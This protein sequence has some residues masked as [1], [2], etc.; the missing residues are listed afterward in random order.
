MA[1]APTR[2]KADNAALPNNRS[3]LLLIILIVLVLTL[4][5]VVG[6]IGALLLLKS[7]DKGDDE[8][9]VS[10]ALATPSYAAPVDLSKPPAFVPLDPFTVNLRREEGEHYLQAVI[11]L[12]VLD[13]KIGDSLKAFMPEIRHRINL[14]LSSQL[15]S[16]LYTTEGRELLAT[17][18]VDETNAALGYP[19]QTDIRGRTTA[20]GPVQAVLFNSF[21]IQ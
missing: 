10:A 3:K 8:A 2:A 21:I 5:I 14:L 15:P 19:V 7:Q 20:A 1:K 16:E 18:I 13:S 4:I 12:R 6:G 17:H 9:D 11:V